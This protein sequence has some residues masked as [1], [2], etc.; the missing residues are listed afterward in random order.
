MLVVGGRSREEGATGPPSRRTGEGRLRTPRE[1]TGR[2][3]QSGTH[4]Y[5]GDA[6]RR[7]IKNA[8]GEW[9]D[10]PAFLGDAGRR[11]IRNAQGAWIDNPAYIASTIPC[12]K[13]WIKNAQ[14]NWVDNPAYA[15][16]AG[17][18]RPPAPE[19]PPGRDPHLALGDEKF[20]PPAPRKSPALKTPAAAFHSELDR[21]RVKVGREPHLFGSLSTGFHDPETISMAHDPSTADSADLDVTFFFD[22]SDF[23][24]EEIS[25]SFPSDTSRRQVQILGIRRVASALLESTGAV[26]DQLAAGRCER[27][28]VDAPYRMVETVENAFVPL[29]RCRDPKTRRS[30]D[31][32]INND[33]G[34]RNSQFLQRYAD[35]YPKFTVPL[36]VEVKRWAKRRGLV[37]DNKNGKLTS[38]GWTL[39]AI[40]FLGRVGLIR[41]NCLGIVPFHGSRET[42]VWVVDRRGGRRRGEKRRTG[43]WWTGERGGRGGERRERT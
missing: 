6:G 43:V 40:A 7:W 14:G 42:C 20:S 37:M 10:N 36:V 41:Y 28:M 17:A 35:T 13:M 25:S 15:G 4:A 9:V 19:D 11:W 22:R 2:S 12:Q 21:L 33:I 5:L 8:Q 23:T 30:V 26:S 39:H 24:E 31:I 29:V 3:S 18:A 16:G 38:Y 27:G 1:S 32:S 34:L